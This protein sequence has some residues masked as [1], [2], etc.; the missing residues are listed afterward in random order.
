MALSRLN[1]NIVADSFATIALVI[2]AILILYGFEKPEPFAVFWGVIF[3][4]AGFII[5]L[6][7][8][9]ASR[10]RSQGRKRRGR[11]QY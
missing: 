4:L 6:M 7:Q 3:G 5:E 10:K 2:A 8:G 1:V 9:T 11:S